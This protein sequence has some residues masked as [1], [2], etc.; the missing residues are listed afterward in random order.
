[1]FTRRFGQK[2]EMGTLMGDMHALGGSPEAG[3]QDDSKTAT[4]KR[5]NSYKK[6]VS[7]ENTKTTAVSTWQCSLNKSG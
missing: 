2:T 6:L 1:M 5:G 3:D 4:M 7:V